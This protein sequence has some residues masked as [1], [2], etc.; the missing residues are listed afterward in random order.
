MADAVDLVRAYLHVNG[1]FTVSEYPVLEQ[2]G[3]GGYRTVT[4]LDVLA[5]RFAGA[6][7]MPVAPGGRSLLAPTLPEPDAALGRGRDEADMIVAEVKEGHARLNKAARDPGVLEAALV[8][9]GCCE[10]K[11]AG[12]VVAR[13]IQKGEASTDHGHRIRLLA[14]GSTVPGGGPGGYT[15]ISLGH[16]LS[17]LRTHLRDNWEVVQHAQVLDPALGFLSLLEK[18]ER[19]T[20]P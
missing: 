12:Q 15:A 2:Q 9:F 20:G 7:P 11:E 1:Y 16:V 8:R 4:D 17:F 6:G 5:F 19:G 3:G 14:F 10:A 13:L 18:A